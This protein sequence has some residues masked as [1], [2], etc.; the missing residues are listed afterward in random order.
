M[1]PSIQ[2]N[3]RIIDKVHKKIKNI[4]EHSLFGVVLWMSLILFL[5]LVSFALGMKYEQQREA[6]RYPVTLGYSQHALNLWNKYQS[7]KNKYQE[8]FASKSG[9]IVYPVGCSK[10][11]RIK[12]ENKIYFNSIEIAEQEGYREV[13][14]C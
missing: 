12:E 11:N 4:L 7:E 6:Q 3:M 9:K 13:E 14:G 8:Y 1:D 5:G 2:S 10:G